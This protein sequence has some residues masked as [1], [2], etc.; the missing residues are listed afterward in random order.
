MTAVAFAIVDLDT[1]TDRQLLDEIAQAVTIWSERDVGKAPPYGWG[2]SAS[3][4][5]AK[6]ASDVLPGEWQIV[7]MSHP[8]VAGALGYHYKTPHGQPYVRAFPKLLSDPSELGITVA[9][10]VVEVLANPELNTVAVG[11]DGL[12]RAQ[13][14]GDPV[15]AFSYPVTIASGKQIAMTAWCTPA[16]FEPPDDLTGIPLAVGADVKTPGEILD[17]GYQILFDAASKQWTTEQKGEMSPYRQKLHELGWGR[18]VA[19]KRVGISTQAS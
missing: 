6:N 11:N 13:E 16:Y 8:D 3:V 17:G 1:N 10:E 18:S 2:I 19:L 5:V 12:L 9:H 15:E 14:P 4:R 7:L